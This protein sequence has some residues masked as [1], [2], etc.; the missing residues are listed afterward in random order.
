MTDIL[1][2]LMLGKGL[3]YVVAQGRPEQCG[4]QR[5]LGRQCVPRGAVEGREARGRLPTRRRGSERGEH[6]VGAL[7]RVSNAPRPQQGLGDLALDEAYL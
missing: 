5:P 4:R 7:F 3:L 2:L 6:G 1:P